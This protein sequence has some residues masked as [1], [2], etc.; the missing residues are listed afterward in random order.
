MREKHTNLFSNQMLNKGWYGALGAKAVATRHT[1][2]NKIITVEL[3]G[4]TLDIPSK[5]LNTQQIATH[6]IFAQVRGLV[7]I[8]VPSYAGGTNPWGT[9]KSKV[10][11]KTF[12][13]SR[14]INGFSIPLFSLHTV[15][16]ALH[17]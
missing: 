4:K 11:R 15:P 7:I 9:K 8:N 5:V 16:K 6:N 3:D 17:C 2:L 12:N 10:V 14:N 13:L 1:A